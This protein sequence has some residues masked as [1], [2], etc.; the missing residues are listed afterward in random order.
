MQL[1]WQARREEFRLP[2]PRKDQRISTISCDVSWNE[3][4][5]DDLIP[6]LSKTRL[7]I[8]ALSLSLSQS[9]YHKTPYLIETSFSSLDAHLVSNLTR[10]LYIVGAYGKVCMTTRDKLTWE[11]CSINWGKITHKDI[12]T[13]RRGW[14]THA[15]CWFV[16]DRVIL[17]IY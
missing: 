15:I 12:F 1:F 10:Y 16:C 13:N 9:R 5:A 17:Q 3:N 11:D 7:L 4:N 14:V 8:L 6:M 2:K